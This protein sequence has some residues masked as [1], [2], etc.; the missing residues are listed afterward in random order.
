[1][2][3]RSLVRKLERLRE[4]ARHRGKLGCPACRDRLGRTALVF[5]DPEGVTAGDAPAPCSV[6]GHVPERIIRIVE[7]VVE[8]TV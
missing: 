4:S 5:V 1:M 2:S 7:T 8:A 6:C 3:A